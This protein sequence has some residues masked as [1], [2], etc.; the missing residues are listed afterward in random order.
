M[1]L[2]D[3]RGRIARAAKDLA[4]A[5]AAA[6]HEWRDVNAQRLEEQ[7]LV[8]LDQRVKQAVTVLDQMYVL[9]EQIKRE[10]Q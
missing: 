9:A 7:L 1:G 3:S 4:T 2:H 5:W 6:R 8:P 10:C